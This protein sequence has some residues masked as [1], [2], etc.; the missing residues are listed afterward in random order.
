MN[1]TFLELSAKEVIC[2]RDGAR[3]GY[4]ND[5][6]L[7]AACGKVFAYLLPDRR[8]FCFSRKPRFRVEVS[9]VER[10][11]EDLIL[12]CRYQCLEKDKRCQKDC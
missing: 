2:T 12:V 9:W 1:M 4:I 11:G 7:D 6:E 10:I 5:L 8:P 3:L